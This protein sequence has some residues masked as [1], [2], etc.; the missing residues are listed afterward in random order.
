[1]QNTYQIMKSLFSAE[2]H[3]ASLATRG[4]LVLGL[5]NGLEKTLRFMRNLILVRLLA[6]DAFGVMAIILA[7]M[8]AFETFTQIG[9]NYFIVQHPRTREHTFLNSAW[10]LSVVRSLILYIIA[11]IAAPWT[12]SF[13]NNPDIAQLMRVAFLVI[14][15][16]GAS[17][18]KVHIAVKDMNF[19]KFVMI[20]S[21]GN[22][23]GVIFTVSLAYALPS[24]WALVLGIVFESSARSIL[25]YIICPFRP[26]L[27][28]DSDSREALFKYARGMFGLPLLTFVFS[29]A[30]VF[31]LGKLCTI[32]D[33]GL[34]SMAISV[35]LIPAQIS[36]NLAGQILL[37]IF[38]RMQDDKEKIHDTLI[39]TTSMIAFAFLP[40]VLF[41]T[42][43][44]REFLQ[45]IYGLQYGEMAIPFSIMLWSVLLQ[46]IGIPI[47]TLYFAL[48]KPEL[49]RRFAAIRAIT[50]IVMIY[51]AVTYLGVA[52]A[53][54]SVLVAMLVSFMSQLNRVCEIVKIRPWEYI[55]IFITAIIPSLCVP[56]IWLVSVEMFNRYGYL[57]MGIF[58]CVLSYCVVAI[59]HFRLDLFKAV[60]VLRSR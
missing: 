21:G 46:I 13:Y 7:V 57:I 19:K 12:A 55:K 60:A 4:S 31:V 49:N 17:S 56:V 41:G 37:P 42:L 27:D 1:M 6:P 35:A 59:I 25:S 54:L 30:D 50:I 11:F 20:G 18:P 33:L 16:N 52:G 5:G 32:A 45:L 22:V 34:Y 28:F 9:I 44:G 53:A 58:G 36:A 8:T 29:K 43:Y 2:G 38:S 3:L 15:I 51:P 24:V 23:L 39:I 40:V 10:W 14:L 47:V 26:G 48:G